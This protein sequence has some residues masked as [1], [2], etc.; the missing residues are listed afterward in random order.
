MKALFQ[1]LGCNVVGVDKVRKLKV[2]PPVLFVVGWKCFYDL[3]EA[4]VKSAS[5]SASRE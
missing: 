1:K 2:I 3:N 5:R 4:S